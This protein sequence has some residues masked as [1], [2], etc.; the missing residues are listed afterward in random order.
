MVKNDRNNVNKPSFK[1]LLWFSCF[2]IIFII[3]LILNFAGS[4]KVIT[5]SG[6]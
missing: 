4:D 3:S 6:K 5:L 1:N 2:K